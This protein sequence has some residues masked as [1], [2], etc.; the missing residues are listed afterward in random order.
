MTINVLGGYDLLI[1]FFGSKLSISFEQIYWKTQFATMKTIVSTNDTSFGV[2]W[3]V[4]TSIYVSI[5][6]ILFF[7][8]ISWILLVRF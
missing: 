5:H 1:A 2:G 3:T 7:F 8:L 6:D 4:F